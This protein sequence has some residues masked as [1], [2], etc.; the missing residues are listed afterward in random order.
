V[1]VK[2]DKI[3]GVHQLEVL[4]RHRRIRARSI[5]GSILQMQMRD[6]KP[7]KETL[8]SKWNPSF[9]STARTFNSIRLSMRE[10]S[11]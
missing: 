9:I 6:N 11:S 7:C 3:I 4:A 2:A 10:R 5:S 8:I 1:S